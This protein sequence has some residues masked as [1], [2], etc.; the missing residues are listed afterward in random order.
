MRAPRKDEPEEEVRR[1]YR[2]SRGGS[3]AFPLYSEQDLVRFRAVHGPPGEL[4]ERLHVAR[5]GC[6]GKAGREATPLQPAETRRSQLPSEDLRSSRSVGSPSTSFRECVR[7][8]NSTTFASVRVCLVPC[9]SMRSPKN[10]RRSISIDAG[11]NYR[12]IFNFNF[13]LS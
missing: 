9:H 2:R 3:G 4:S 8:R 10:H 7:R 11:R 5:P 6:R 12:I 1:D 13:K